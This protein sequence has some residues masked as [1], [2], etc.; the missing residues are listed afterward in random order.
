MKNP[1]LDKDFLKEL[2]QYQH[3]EIYAKITALNFNELPIE[4][5][6][7]RITGGS[8]N[9][10][11]TSVVRRTCNLTLVAAEVNINDFYWGI[12]NKFKLEIGL[13]NFINPDYPDIIWFNKGKYCITGFNVSYTTNNYSIS[14]SGQDKMC[15]LNG[16]LGGSLYASIDFGQIETY[17]SIYEEVDFSE[18]YTIFEAGKYYYY[19]K[20][21]TPLNGQEEFLLATTKYNKNVQYYSK[22]LT[23]NLESL[24]LKRIIR[25]AVHTYAN[26][27]YHNII[28]NDLDDYGL[29]LL[30]YR[31]DV[32][33]YFFFEEGICENMTYNGDILVI[34]KNWNEPKKLSE[35]DINKGEINNLVEEFNDNTIELELY[36]GNGKK[37]TIAKIEYGETAGYRLTDLIYAGEL[38]ANVGETL[39]SILDKIKN[40]LGD[41]E[42]FYD[43]DGRF[44]FQKK[45]TYVNS[46]WNTLVE[47]DDNDLYA[48][49]ASYTSEVQYSFEDNNLITSFSNNPQLN[50]LKNDFSVW[51]VRKGI[52]DADISIHARYAID[53]K[54][55][56]YKAFD[57]KIYMTDE[58]HKEELKD[59]I[60][61]QVTENLKDRL[62]KFQPTYGTYEGLEA[63]TKNEDGSWTPGW[64]DIRDWAEYYEILTLEKPIYTMKWYSKNNSEGYVSEKLIPGG[65]NRNGYCWL[66]IVQKRNNG[67]VYV[68]FQHGEGSPSQGARS[69]LLYYSYYNQYGA[70]YT[71]PVEPYEYKTFMYP[72]AGC[73]DN[74][75]YLSFLENDIKKNGNLVYFYNPDFPNTSSSFDEIVEDQIDKEVDNWFENGNIKVVDWREIIYQMALDY[76]AH[77]QEEDF[78]ITL[79]N[80]NYISGEY[81]YKNGYTGYEQYYTDIQGFWRQLYD[82][83]PEVIRET[84]GGKYEEVRVDLNQEEGT[85]KIEM[86]WV[87]YK[88]NETD[89]FCDFYLPENYKTKD[90][91]KCSDENAEKHFSNTYAYWNKNVVLAP[92]LLNFWIEFL[93]DVGELESYSIP[94][95]G[96]RAK[97]V[98]DSDVSAIYFRETPNIIF[99]SAKDYDPYN[100][101]TG[102]VYIWLQDYI[103]NSFVISSQG[104]SA[105][106]KIDE[107][108]YNYT[109]CVESV[110]LSTIPVYYLEPNARIYIHD[111]DSKINGDYIVSKLTI[112]LTYNGTMSITATKAVERLY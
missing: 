93:D 14:I 48:E 41:F 52:N 22:L 81:L 66:I 24:P 49:N 97:S 77:N 72:Y 64:W 23:S 38:I 43:I 54:P 70:L 9:I 4:W 68:N 50:N 89:F 108:L 60:R 86:Q 15:M 91:Y 110:S 83:E 1:L 20:N 55:T 69:C 2:D 28:I 74:H 29:E 39:T 101:Q 62:D 11:G 37:Y 88:E 21:Y 90:Y 46:Y 63:P 96:D 103:E 33:L 104:K 51:G 105:K 78:L 53:K 13:K 45:K 100:I 8:I 32:P 107:L 82:T 79:K 106:D 26:E 42:Y 27:P 112:P 80:N 35:L 17:D 40:M 56:F 10:D 3:K 59:A 85:Y 67:N 7:G 71:S 73:S 109:Y 61:D 98:N 57:G 102:Y 65:E 58:R 31:G 75:T 92:E 87:D 12:T 19:N 5:I 44:I 99:T 76:F 6:E 18:D 84:S 94:Y 34:H 25:E 47:T 30:E 111:E 16:T 36:E 95:I